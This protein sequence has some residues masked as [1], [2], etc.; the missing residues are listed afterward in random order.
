LGLAQESK[1]RPT[2][3][4]ALKV[5]TNP[6]LLVIA[7]LLYVVEFVPDKIQIVDTAWGSIQTF[8]RPPAAAAVRAFAGAGDVPVVWKLGAALLAGGVAAISL[9]ILIKLYRF[10]TRAVYWISRR[11]LKSGTS[12][13]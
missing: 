8:I 9:Y 6:Y 12:A 10:V 13:A 7:C 3:R 11:K 1:T 2:N 5:L 4:A